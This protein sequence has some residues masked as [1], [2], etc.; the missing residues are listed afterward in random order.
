MNLKSRGRIFLVLLSLTWLMASTVGM[1]L[2][3]D[4]DSALITNSAS[5]GFDS[6][7]CTVF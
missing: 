2:L 5:R 4:Y 3:A 6:G 7:G 1:L